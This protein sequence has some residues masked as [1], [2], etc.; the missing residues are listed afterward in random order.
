MTD[1][2]TRARQRVDRRRSVRFPAPLALR[3]LA[4]DGE[5]ALACAADLSEDGMFVEFVLPYDEGTQLRVELDLPG[6]GAFWARARVQSAQT[7][8]D[9]KEGR[10]P[11]NGLEFVDISPECEARLRRYLERQLD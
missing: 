1:R 10:V 3:V 7:W 4:Q 9:P 6:E 5:L 11:G 2:R 8:L